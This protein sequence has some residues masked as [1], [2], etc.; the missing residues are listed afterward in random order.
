M[1]F[2]EAAKL[3]KDSGSKE[4]WL[5]HY[6]PALTDP[7]YFINNARSIFPNTKAAHDRM[8]TTLIFEEN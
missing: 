7:E 6:S 2:A 1:I 4:L 5:T 3:A 8:S